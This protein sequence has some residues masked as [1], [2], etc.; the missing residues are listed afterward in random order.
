MSQARKTTLAHMQRLAAAALVGNV[1]ACDGCGHGY[2]VVDPMPTPGRVTGFA[3]AITA[4][5]SFA[6]TKI[7]LEVT[8]PGAFAS[9]LA[10]GADAA[11]P[12]YAVSGGRVVT[13]RPVSDGMELVIEP[14]A[15]RGA[16]Y[17]R[18][19]LAGMDAGTVE[20]TVAWGTSVDGGRDV[21]VTMA[22][23]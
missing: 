18:F 23:R 7:V 8:A 5:A 1:A 11:T 22:D 3:S 21:T 4:H 12:P 14:D 16:L 9:T 6:G 15:G 17:V 2:A 13:T 10:A 19:N 20:A